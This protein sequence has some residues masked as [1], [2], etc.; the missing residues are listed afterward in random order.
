[1]TNYHAAVIVTD[2]DNVDYRGLV[3]SL[4]LVV[5]SRN[6]CDRKGIKDPKI[7]KA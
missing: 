5:D 4:P 2:H 7:V 3:A 6:V 1:M